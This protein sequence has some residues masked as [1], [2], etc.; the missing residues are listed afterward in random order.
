MY[1]SSVASSPLSAMSSNSRA[2]A[3]RQP[4]CCASTPNT[5]S[6][7]R[8]ACRDA[9]SSARRRD[10]GGG[11]RHGADGALRRNVGGGDVGAP[12]PGPGR[13]DERRQASRTGTSCM[14]DLRRKC[15]HAAT[16]SAKPRTVRSAARPSITTA[17]PCTR[18]FSLPSIHAH[19][20]VLHRDVLEA[21]QHEIRDAVEARHQRLHA[22]VRA[23]ARRDLLTHQPL[24]ERADQLV[25][26]RLVHVLA[27]G[28]H[29]G[30][31]HG[32]VPDV[33]QAHLHE[34]VRARR[35]PARR[36]RA[37]RRGARR[38]RSRPR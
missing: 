17:R 16:Y 26:H 15:A 14:M 27:P 28:E 13:R 1:P 32:A 18:N 19:Q 4:S 11:G 36:P 5:S 35:A 38:P 37:P 33:E 2:T 23:Q 21:R 29:A 20:R 34:L 22:R 24:Q 12:R 9:A 7:S 30:V 8:N 6:M 25:R 10:G 31:A 3:W